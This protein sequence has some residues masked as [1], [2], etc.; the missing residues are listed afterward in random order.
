LRIWTWLDFVTLGLMSLA[1]PWVAAYLHSAWVYHRGFR[2]Y[3]AE[4]GGEYFFNYGYGYGSLEPNLRDLI[5]WIGGCGI[6]GIITFLGLLWLRR[7]P[8]TCWIVWCFFVGLWTFLLF[9]AEVAIK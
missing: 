9:Q 6:P 1:A 8:L 4:I 2:I 3:N 5:V 7:R